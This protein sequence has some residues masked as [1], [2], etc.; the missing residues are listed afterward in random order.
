MALAYDT[1]T[2]GANNTSTVSV[3]V[4]GTNPVLLTFIEG[5]TTDTLNSATYNGVGMTFVDKIKTPSDRYQYCYILF[6]PA[7]GTHNLVSSGS[8]FAQINAISYTGNLSTAVDNFTDAT[9]SAATSLSKNLT[10]KAANCWIVMGGYSSDGTT[11]AGSGFIN[12]G[13]INDGLRIMDTNGTVSTGTNACAFTTAGSS[14]LSLIA[15]SI[16]PTPSASG[17]FFNLL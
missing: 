16:S 17:G 4:T 13:I 2:N 11:T 8:T 12:R 7:T 9:A 15:V 3:T 5:D 10:V 14:N 6:N 1:V